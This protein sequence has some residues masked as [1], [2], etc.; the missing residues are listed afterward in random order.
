MLDIIGMIV[1][2]ALPLAL[3]WLIERALGVDL[4]DDPQEKTIISSIN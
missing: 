3:I 4:L 2:A 1:A